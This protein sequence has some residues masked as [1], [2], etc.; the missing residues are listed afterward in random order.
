MVTVEYSEAAVE[1]LGIIETLEEEEKNKIPEE[2]IN[3]LEENKSKEY[4]PDIDYYAD[5][6]DLKLKEKTKQ[7]LAGI[8]RDYLCNEE[9][10][11]EYIKKLRENEIEYQEKLRKEYNTDNLFKKNNQENNKE[12]TMSLVVKKENLF[13][14]IINKIKNFFKSI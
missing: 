2:I 4:N 3:F 5:V 13:S 10:K 6:E 14:R 7:I 1:V 12:T 8:Y 9:E 11:Q